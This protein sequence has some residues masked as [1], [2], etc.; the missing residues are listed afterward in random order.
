MVAS[1]SVAV[2]RSARLRALT[3]AFALVA[4]SVGTPA[5][6]ATSSIGEYHD[7]LDFIWYGNST[8]S[9]QWDP[10]W[11]ETNDDGSAWTGAARI[12][13]DPHC[14]S[15]L[16][17][18]IGRGGGDDAEISRA[19]DLAAADTAWLSFNR[20]RHR[21]GPGAGSVR[22]SVSPSGSGGWVALDEWSLDTTDPAAVDENF[23]ISSWIGA[24]TT[25]RFELIGGSDDSHLNVDNVR[26]ELF[27]EDNEAPVLDPIANQI[28]DEEV[29]FGFTATATDPN[30]GDVLSFKL[31]GTEPAGA[32]IT[33]DGVF[34]W[35]PTEAQGPG[36]YS[37]DVIV[38]DDA[39]PQLTDSQTVTLTVLEVNASPTLDPVG[40]RAVEEGSLLSF[41]A[42]AQDAETATPDL[43]YEL[44]GGA[45]AGAVM[46]AN[47][48]FTWTPTEAQGPG[49]YDMDVKVWDDD[50][51][52]AYAYET[53][54]VTV[55]EKN[56]S[57][58]LTPIPTQVVDEGDEVSFTAVAT[59]PDVPSNGLMFTMAGAPPGAAISPTGVF[60]WTPTD[61]Q[62]PGTFNFDV[63]VLDDGSPVRSDTEP[64]TIVVNEANIAP[65]INSVS[66]KTV[67][68]G[69]VLQF[70]VTATD[71]D[72]PPNGFDFSLAGA[73]SGASITPGGTFSW[74]PTESQGP[75]TVSFDIVATDDGVPAMSSSV[76][77]TV[78]VTE[79]N[80]APVLSPIAPHSINEGAPF[81]LQ[82]VAS[83]ADVP[84]NGLSFTM[85]GAPSGATVSPSGLFTWTPSEDQGPG[86]FS[87][88]VVVS[89]DGSP[90]L[91][92]SQ[93]MTFTVADAN[94]APVIDPIGTVSVSETEL[95]SFTATATDPD[96]PAN[97][98]WFKLSGN[99][100]SGASITSGGDF[101]WIP[102]ESHGPGVYKFDVVVTDTGSP[103]RSSNAPVTVVVN[104]VNQAPVLVVPAEFT[105]E[106]GVPF[107]LAI[108]ATDSD[109]PEQLLR[110]SALGLPEAAT[111]SDGG[112]L[113]WVPGEDSAGDSYEVD[114]SVTDDGSPPL[115]TTASFMLRVVTANAA[116]VLA[117]IG[118]RAVQAGEM[119]RFVAKATDEDGP[120]DALSYSLSAD[121][122]TGALMDPATGVFEWRPTTAQDDTAFTFT[123][124]VTD[125]GLV[126]KSDSE[127]ITVT[128]GR[129]NQAPVV[130]TPPNQKS[131][132]GETATLAIS[133]SD[134]D[135]YPESLSFA[136]FNLPP[137]LEID[138]TT[139]RIT[140][141]PGFDGLAGSPHRVEVVVSDGRDS[142]SIEF[143][144]AVTG[145]GS[146][147]PSTPTRTAVI[148]GINEV[149]SS[150]GPT[151]ETTTYI[152]RSLVL[153]ARAVRSGVSEMSL[154]FL[155]L[156]VMILGVA[157][158][159][160]IGIVPIFRR[161]TRHD[162]ILVNYDVATG[163]GLVARV[164]DGGEVFVHASAITRRDRDHLVP[165]DIVTFRTVDGAYRDLVTK[166]R[167][168][169]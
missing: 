7:S 96:V 161:R 34:T 78:T 53:I 108:N 15:G 126:P 18:T 136:A 8:G 124:K 117:P 47:G 22:L 138:G 44:Y 109:L 42:T 125:A 95:L 50:A 82:L 63:V 127:R 70:V 116:P 122:P 153:M 71:P 144:W 89:D 131:I 112:E 1:R 104:E 57:P 154:P 52:P 19:A 65:V 36:V 25:I 87:F 61:V 92:D 29:P 85:A 139:G 37:F 159:G 11:I 129:P 135:A 141:S 14:A 163:A 111:L 98:F 93:T 119:V 113:S 143:D 21:H 88:D 10:D 5:A 106:A 110:Y 142:T 160:R 30:G 59:D 101:T 91:S 55:T 39:E 45:P 75:G 168:R 79:V 62:G 149:T 103:S 130:V 81:V 157:S 156:V 97:T 76:V 148:A 41:V 40:N 16:C 66:P 51:A 100:P 23:D 13:L 49:S 48:V 140:G 54:T 58:Q 165:G 9:L 86:T 105:A 166:L 94:N 146:P 134:P 74:T 20:K 99:V 151:A 150:D 147:L 35:T 2:P 3:I 169:R 90:A 64:V 32:A 6:Q 72:S 27:T 73:P 152:G 84:A 24:N 67:A 46:S 121:A 123:V 167:K 164:A 28:I 114:L 68:E 17:L 118:D 115:T 31:D 60:T 43:F 33:V 162:G 132:P 56:E 26:I 38:C 12:G 145:V 120:L 83:D 4:L 128:V 77:V 155:L 137:G 80:T 69:S 133:A 102:D 107:L 158:L